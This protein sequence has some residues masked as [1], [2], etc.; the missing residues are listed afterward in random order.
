MVP[1]VFTEV[2]N[3]S[4]AELTK[5]ISNRGST[6]G[7]LARIY[8]VEVDQELLDQMARMGL[9]IKVDLPEISEGYRML[10]GFLEHLTERTVTD[11]AVDY[12][13]IFLGAGAKSGDGAYPYESVYTSP[14][15]LV[16]QDARDQ[17]FKLYR[18]EGLDRAEELNEPEDHI[19]VELEFMSY[20]CQK[21]TEALKDGDKGGA[22]GYLKKQNDFLEEHLMRWVPAFCDDVQ[23]VALG[24][25]YKAVA[26]ITIGYLSMEK[27][28]IGELVDEI[29]G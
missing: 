7:F 22:L 5:L 2:K 6:Y 3:F 10:K 9:S 27:D 21:T 16:M 12:A 1:E 29:Q 20:L 19:A 28:L 17:V 8:R 15:G 23:R 18:E 14:E 25:F 26:N 24:D 4:T 11:L 13:R